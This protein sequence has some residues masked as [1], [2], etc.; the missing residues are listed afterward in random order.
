MRIGDNVGRALMQSGYGNVFVTEELGRIILTGIVSTDEDKEIAYHIAVASA[1]GWRV[2]NQIQVGHKGGGKPEPP[3]ISKS[4]VTAI[5][6]EL[7][8]IE[9]KEENIFS[10]LRG[11]D[12]KLDAI[13]SILDRKFNAD[14]LAAIDAVGVSVKALRDKVRH[15]STVPPAGT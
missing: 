12:D 7:G 2:F 10:F 8:K 1:Y 15:I 13:Q 9:G 6:V 5:L 4:D 14:D 3:P 11:M